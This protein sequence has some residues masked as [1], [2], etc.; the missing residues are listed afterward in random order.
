VVVATEGKLH[1]NEQLLNEE[2]CVVSC[3]F[4]YLRYTT[5]CIFV[6]VNYN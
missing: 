2:R 3:D 6:F 5:V 4:L 1:E